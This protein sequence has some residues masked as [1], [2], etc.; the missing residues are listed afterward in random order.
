[1]T[2]AELE[3]KLNTSRSL[4]IRQWA[5]ALLL[6]RA[7]TLSNRRR[8]KSSD[9]SES[10]WVVDLYG[11]L[12]E[13]VLYSIVRRLPASEEAVRYLLNHIFLETGGKGAV[14]PDLLFSEGQQQIGIDAKTFNCKTKNRFFAIND[15]KHQHLAGQCLGYVG[16]IC[17]LWGRLAYVTS[18][19]P[20]DDVSSWSCGQLRK[21]EKGKQ[22]TPSR[23]LDIRKAMR[24][25]ARGSYSIEASRS[26]VHP[27]D[28]VWRAALQTD[29]ES[30][31]VFLS[32]LLPKAAGYL[33]EAQEDLRRT[34]ESTGPAVP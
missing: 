22:G 1:M 25:Y 9:R 31:M 18:V 5:C 21:S 26:N 2:R 28:K 4:T 23:N 16:L 14:G 32:E 10:N 20:Y 27:Q 24:L 11:A 30:V 3:E 29:K 17:P 12:G 15:N 7:R 8:H 19:I 6:G 13:L 34:Q 33:P